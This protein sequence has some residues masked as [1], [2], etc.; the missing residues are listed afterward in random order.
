M[1]VKKKKIIISE[2]P[3]D[4]IIISEEPLDEKII[5]ENIKLTNEE[6]NNEVIKYINETIIKSNENDKIAI[7]ELYK[8]FNKTTKINMMLFKFINV[9]KEM[10]ITIE[11]TNIYYVVGYKLK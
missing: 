8:M 7:K 4:K 11:K 1:P 6:K 10:N 9:L 2:E 5:N 3:S